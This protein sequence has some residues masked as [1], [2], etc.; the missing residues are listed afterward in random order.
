VAEHAPPG[1]RAY[2]TSFIQLTATAGLVLSLLVILVCRLVLGSDFDVWGWRVPFMLSIILLGISIYIRLQLEES[3]VFHEMRRE[4]RISKR[5]IA[6]SFARWDNLKLVLLALFG[7]MTGQA[8][9]GYCGLVYMLLFLTQTLKVEAIVANV[10]VMVALGVCAPFYLL[11]GRLADRIGRKPLV[12]VGC[13]LAGLSF[14]PLFAGLTRYANPAIEAA[15]RNNPVTVIADPGECSFQFDPIGKA[16]FRTSCDVAKTALT[17]LG[18]PYSNQPAAPGTPATVQIGKASLS[19]FDGT[20]L[21]ATVFH[22][23]SAEFRQRLLAD[24]TSAGY[25]SSA[26]TDRVDYPMVLLLLILIGLCG[27]MT[28]APIAAWLVELFPP[29]IR[30]TSMSLPYHIGNGWFGGFVPTIAFALN[31]YTGN[32]YSG[33]WYVVAICALTTVVGG[34]FL[35]ETNG[36]ALQ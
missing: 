17:N 22:A 31:A 2:Y 27:V 24:L 4:G 6:E 32:M 3:P 20:S 21:A 11:F 16:H 7:A 30:Y 12:I 5:P 28:Y 19:A 23:R 18:V 25:P 13:V 34:L 35:R 33:L 9:V 29:Q 8:V 10:L 1:R 26:D 14:F 15:Q 36:H